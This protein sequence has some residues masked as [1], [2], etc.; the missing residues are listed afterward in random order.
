MQIKVTQASL[1]LK[2][3]NFWDSDLA[4]LMFL[5]QECVRV[6]KRNRENAQKLYKQSEGSHSARHYTKYSIFNNPWL[7]LQ[8]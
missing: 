3:P 4:L 2:F 7:S 6:W 5:E 1:L 8:I